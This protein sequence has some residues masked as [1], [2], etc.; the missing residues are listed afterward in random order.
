MIGCGVGIDKDHGV[1]SA[2]RGAGPRVQRSVGEVDEGG[3]IRLPGIKL[4]SH[5]EN[6]ENNVMD[7]TVQAT[8]GWLSSVN[9]QLGIVEVNSVVSKD[10]SLPKVWSIRTD[11]PSLHD[12]YDTYILKCS[13]GATS[14]VEISLFNTTITLSSRDTRL[15]LEQ[16]LNQALLE[17]TSNFVHY[18]TSMIKQP[19]V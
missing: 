17:I 3:I 18:Q 16:Q 12:Q 7:L 9:S 19:L 4:L 14:M 5:A 6:T 11:R 13:L 10:R 8:T 1:A 15:T 2:I